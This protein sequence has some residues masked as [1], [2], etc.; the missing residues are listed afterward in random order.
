MDST[1]EF[2]FVLKPA[3]YGVGVF[4]VH[5]V[6]EGTYL[7]LFRGEN[8]TSRDVWRNRKDVPEIFQEYC[9]SRGEELRC[10]MD[11]GKMEVGWYLNHSK[12]PN[13]HHKDYNYYAL[14]DIKVGEEISVDY[15]S[16]DEPEDSKADYYK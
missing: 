8:E 12:T 14:K 2:S 16:F 5:D 3:E 11:F 10:P 13:T 9:L 4:A 6:K 15:S 7:R 1:N